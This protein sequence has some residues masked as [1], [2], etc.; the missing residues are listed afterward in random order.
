MAR[1]PN[2]E[3]PHKLLQAARRVFAAAGFDGARIQDIAAEAGFS[4]AAFYLYFQ[5]KEEV[6]DRLTAELFQAINEMTDAR[7]VAFCGLIEKFGPCDLNDWQTNSPRLK[8]YLDL[9]AKYGRA[10]LAIMW[11]NRD[12][13]QCVLEQTGQ[14]RELVEQFVG[15]VQHT[16]S[17]RLREAMSFGILR[18]DVDGDLAAEMIIGIYMHFAR[19]MT[20]MTEAPDL[21]YW[22]RS[23]D[24]FVSGGIGSHS[25]PPPKESS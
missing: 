19:R 12:T 24:K 23:I 17:G 4:K 9:D 15:M 11:D 16:L 7:H 1:P 14:R 22:A 10:A 6:F 5:S 13:V 8:A 2:P 3:A 20:R 21:D 18:S 25:V